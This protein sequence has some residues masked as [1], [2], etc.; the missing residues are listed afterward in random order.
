MDAAGVHPN[1]AGNPEARV[2]AELLHDRILTSIDARKT[3]E[4]IDVLP[5]QARNVR[6]K[7]GSKG[8]ANEL[9]CDCGSITEFAGCLFS[10]KDDVPWSHP[11]KDGFAL[12]I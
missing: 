6:P 2:I 1:M 7:P 5:R 11:L 4:N 9:R 12:L 10:E 3:L 8:L